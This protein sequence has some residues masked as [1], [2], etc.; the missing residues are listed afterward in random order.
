MSDVD[1]FFDPVCPWAWITSRWVTEVVSLRNLQVDWKFISLRMVNSQRDYE[2]EFPS[3]YTRTHTL[4]LQLLRVASAVRDDAGN[5]GVARLYSALGQAIHVDKRLGEMS[6]PKLVGSMLASAGLNANL[7][8]A[9]DDSSRDATISA[10]TQ[11]ALDRA[12]KDIGTPVLTFAPP[13][14]P[15]FF[16]PVIS[17]IPRGEEALALWDAT[18]KIA[19]FQG[20]AELKRSLREAPQVQ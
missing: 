1:F 16:G 2:S 4:G 11:L 15:S 3:G 6:E 9:L 19:R 13:D 5:D 12:G 20:F 18:E 17:R 10:E 8:G 7:A 14:G